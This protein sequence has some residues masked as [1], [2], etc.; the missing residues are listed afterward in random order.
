M[1]IAKALGVVSTALLTVPTL[2]F[3]QPERDAGSDRAVFETSKVG[4]EGQTLTW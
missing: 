1:P 4:F 2:S 3:A